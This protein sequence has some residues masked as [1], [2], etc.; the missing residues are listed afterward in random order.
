MDASLLWIVVAVNALT[1]AGGREQP[2]RRAEGFGVGRGAA[3]VVLRGFLDRLGGVSA[4]M[5]TRPQ[6]VRLRSGWMRALC[7]VSAQK[8]SAAPGVIQIDA[9]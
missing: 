1:A 8:D 3:G 7:E 5:L 4:A 2:L 9:G 6:G